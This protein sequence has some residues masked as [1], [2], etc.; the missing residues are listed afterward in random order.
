MSYIGSNKDGA[1]KRIYLGYWANTPTNE[2]EAARAYDRAALEIYG[3]FANL[4]FPR[5]DYK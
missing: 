2:I 5:E 1:T 4:N 3:E